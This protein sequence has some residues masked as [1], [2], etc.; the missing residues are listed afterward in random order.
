M[1]Q[2]FS[3]R[4]APGDLDA[5]D[6][7]V[8]ALRQ[9]GHALDVRRPRFG[10]P[11]PETIG[12]ACWRHHLRRHHERERH[13]RFHPSRDRIGCACRSRRRSH[14]SASVSARRCW[15]T[16][17]AA[18]FIVIRRPRRGRIL[19]HPAPD[20]DRA[21]RCA[22]PGRRQVTSGIARGSTCRSAR[23]CWQR[24]TLFPVQ[25]F[26]YGGA[27]FALQFHPDVTHAMMCRWTTRGHERMS[28]PNAKPRGAH[29]ADRAVYDPA[30]PRP[31]SRPSSITGW[32]RH[33]RGSST[34]S[35]R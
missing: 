8:Y 9:R 5:P 31:G 3:D 34:V 7:L 10:D 18:A 1:P 6:A 22:T 16:I 27:A 11:L 28:L 14:S 29:F 13:R 20:P 25:A 12:G 2:P 4:A 21:A 24:A 17:S 32:G 19:P 15:R 30:G 26:R 23:T 35:S 33:P